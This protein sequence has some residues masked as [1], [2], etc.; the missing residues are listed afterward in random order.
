MLS[1]SPLF[2]RKT[3]FPRIKSK[4]QNER[5]GAERAA[6]NAPIQGSAA[7]IIRRAM[8]RMPGALASA[9]LK[10]ARMLLQV[11]DE[12]LFATPLG[13]QFWSGTLVYYWHPVRAAAAR[14]AMDFYELRHY[15]ATRLL[16]AGI[17]DADVAVQLGHT[18]GGEL[19]RKV[20]GHPTARRALE[21]VRE[22]LDRDAA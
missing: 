9:G 3:H 2:G 18:D 14:P 20:Y 1:R 5:Q 4:Q 8:V 15:C 16:E 22:A 11:H 12:L 21:N 6:I 17:S 13:R 7:D 19:V 10:S